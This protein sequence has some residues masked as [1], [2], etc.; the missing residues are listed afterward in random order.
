[1]KMSDIWLSERA[2]REILGFK[3]SATF[4]CARRDL[5]L[6][7]KFRVGVRE[8]YARADVEHVRDTCAGTSLSGEQKK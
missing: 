5:N 1:M 4:K 8:Y 7:P 6:A 3:N 2:V